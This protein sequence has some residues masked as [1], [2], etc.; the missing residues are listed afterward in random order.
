MSFGVFGS[1]GLTFFARAENG[2]VVQIRFEPEI[3]FEFFTEGRQQGMVNLHDVLA[4]AANQMM[5]MRMLVQFVFDV[6][7]S[8]IRLVD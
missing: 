6:S 1:A 8:Q 2:K 4:V 7:V 3:A 5:M